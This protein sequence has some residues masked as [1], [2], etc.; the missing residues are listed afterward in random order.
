[1][2]MHREQAQ[3]RSAVVTGPFIKSAV[4]GADD[5]DWMT[6]AET[7]GVGTVRPVRRALALV[8]ATVVA[9]L[10]LLPSTVR[11]A[12]AHAADPTPVASA[13]RWR[14]CSKGFE[15]ASLPV[16]VDHAAPD[17]E[18]VDVA[19]IRAPARVESRR[20]G[21]LVVNFGGPGDAGTETLPLAIATIPAVIR[22][23]FDIV[24]F[25]PRGTGSTRPIDCIDDRTTDLL[26]TEDPT[27]DDAS[28]LDRFYTGTNSAVDVDASCIDRYGAWLGAVG[29]RN[30][31]RDVDRI[32]AALGERRL[33]FLGYSYGTVLGAV[34]AQEF[35]TRV[36]TMVLDGAVDLSASPEAEQR[37]NAA[38]FEHALDEFLGW[39][40]DRRSCP[41]YSDGDPRGALESLRNRFETGVTVPAGDGRRAGAGTFYLGLLVALYD[42]TSG[43]PALAVGLQ[44]ATSG[45]GTVLQ[46]L[47]DT[48]LGRDGDGHYNSLQEAI[49][50]IRCADAPAP[51]PAFPEFRA[52]FEA[53]VRD[54]PFL[55]AVIAGTPAGCDPRLPV[56][57]ADAVL[58][59]VRA[60]GV[61][62][63]LIIGTTN[64]PA[65]PYDG[66]LDLQQRLAGSRILTVDATQHGAYGRG[67][68]CIDDAVDRYLLTRRL[69]R[70][71]IRCAG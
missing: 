1:M 21:T 19:L 16:P 12:Q 3:W 15:C 26:V 40:A 22:D 59:D 33:T 43:W 61:A 53:F 57:E 46:I 30:V 17:G 28:E 34:Y 62:P 18:T 8:V 51:T 41:F 31:A 48:F 54:F 13:R 25:D 56:P 7:Q 64:D 66:A 63:I 71:G 5:T 50:V 10:A 65:T 32:R 42:K 44:R 6:V 27:P 29:T 67:I 52:T 69:P 24:S 60:T 4:H 45:D 70:E 68:R 49:G 55:G 14:A 39:C 23:R 35:P 11:P 37:A 2:G 58:G 47:A 38:G 36:R 9:G 20:I